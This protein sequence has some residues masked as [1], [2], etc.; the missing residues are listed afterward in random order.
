[1]NIVLFT[2]DFTPNIGGVAAHV[3][4]LAK[5]L[6]AQGH[7][8]VVIFTVQDGSRFEQAT[9]DGFTLYRVPFATHPFLPLRLA[10][11]GQFT[12]QIQQLLD[13]HQAEILH[14]HTI[15]P[16]GLISR[17]VQ[18]QGMGKIFTNHTSGYLQMIQSQ[19]G[20]W[21]ARLHL[22]HAH[23]VIAPSEELAQTS[24]LL[25]LAPERIHFIPNG[26]DTNRFQPGPPDL[27]LR[28]RYGL[29]DED[30]VLICPRRIVPKNGVRYL[31]QA[32][33]QI[34]RA[35]ENVRVLIIGRGDADEEAFVR[36][37]LEKGG[38]MERVIFAGAVAN[39]E[40]P[41]HYRLGHVA[42]L[43]SLME[44]V[45]IAGL[46]AMSTGLP[47]V[48]TNVGGIPTLINEG[49]SGFLVPPKDPAALAE[50]LI[51][52][53]GNEELCRSLG[54]AA[55]ARV[56]AH[57]DWQAIAHRTTAIYGQCHYGD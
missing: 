33:P 2:S 11:M 47:L 40:M 1:M 25:G 5:A 38:V 3:H 26:V 24:Q 36:G 20:R 12:R 37:E 34:A 39:A 44:A 29:T 7:Q 22:G 35:V 15:R 51:R 9:M 4:E 53:L 8:V 23:Q 54:D 49:E 28:Q 27:A 52:L 13:D 46:E 55:R 21:L 30:R 43:P 32:V 57:F 14:W 50:A 10:R 48:G 31:A 19:R 56:I 6:V 42:V 18:R 45:S 16:E 41:Q 17:W